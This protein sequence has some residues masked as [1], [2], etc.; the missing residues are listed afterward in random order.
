MNNYLNDIKTIINDA[1]YIVIGAGAGL[2]AAAGLTYSGDR[3]QSN[4]ADFIQKFKLPD[5]YSAAFYDY[6]NSETLWGYWCRHINMNRYMPLPNDTYSKLL[7]IVKD[8]KYFVITTNVDH[9]FIRSGFDKNSV[10]YTQGNYGLFQCSVPCHHET[11]DN[12]QVI[13]QM[14]KAQTGMTVPTELIPLCPRCG[15]EMSPNL[16]KDE[17]FVQ[18]SGWSDAANRYKTFVSENNQNKMVYLELGVGYNTP[19]I[20]KF[21]FRQLT[22]IN[23]NAFYICVN[24]QD[25]LI[26]KEITHRSLLVTDD[27]HNFITELAK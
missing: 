24:Q 9:A 16:R 19:T 13:E 23:K 7:S 26:P 8:K 25:D 15:K 4:F 3:F 14:L 6:P 2:S 5:M 11:Y 12:Q 10:F 20:I 27:I 22:Y 21:P 1:D 18:D 17:T